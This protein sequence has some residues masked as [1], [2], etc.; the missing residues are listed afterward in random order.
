MPGAKPRRDPA[1]PKRPLTS[2]MLF[3]SDHRQEI[4][5]SLPL[6]SPNSHFLVEAGKHW[7]ALDD[8]EREPYKARAEELKAAYLKEM[9]DFLASGGVIPKKERR[10]RTGTKLRK[11]V[12]RKDPLEPKK[13]QTA[14]MFW[15][16]ENREQIA[17]ELPADQRSM[18]DVTQEAGRRWKVLGTKE[19]VP[20]LKKADAEKAKYLKE[21]REYE[22][23][24][25][26]S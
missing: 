17:A 11:K 3:V 2:F 9:E 5:D 26:G 6:D 20:F 13:P 21:M 12:R 24:L 10:A 25:A 15:L 19:K 16:H 18:T 22:A 1:I 7:R 23:F 4:K 14:W 8:S